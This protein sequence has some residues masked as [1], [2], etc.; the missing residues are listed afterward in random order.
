MRYAKTLPLNPCCNLYQVNVLLMQLQTWKMKDVLMFPHKASGVI[1][2][3]E[4][5]LIW[6]FLILMPSPTTTS[7]FHLPIAYM[8]IKNRGLMTKVEHS[9]FSPLVFSTSRGME[10]RA[11]VTYK[12]LAYLLSIKREKSYTTVRAWIQCHLCFTLLRS[13]IMCLRGARSH[14]HIPQCESI[15]LGILEGKIPSLDV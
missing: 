7:S 3:R 10:A 12:C 15:N 9:S 8:R 14:H 13:A 2:I 4:P 6:G 5:F 1:D 11:T